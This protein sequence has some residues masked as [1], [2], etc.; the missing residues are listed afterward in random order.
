MEAPMPKGLYS[1]T[2]ST[3]TQW[4]DDAVD[5]WENWPELAQLVVHVAYSVRPWLKNAD[6]A[7]A[8]DQTYDEEHREDQGLQGFG[9]G[10]ATLCSRDWMQ[11]PEM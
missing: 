2:T 4:K 5:K 8:D 9:R 6:I 1:I 10:T 11:M 3:I 7:L